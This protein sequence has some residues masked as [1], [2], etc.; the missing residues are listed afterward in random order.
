[1][2]KKSIRPIAIVLQLIVLATVTWSTAWADSPAITRNLSDLQLPADIK[3]HADGRLPI[4]S[5]YQSYMS[6]L[7]RGW[8][9]DV[10]AR[11]QPSGTNFALP[12]IALRSPRVGKA[13]WILAGIHGE[14]PAGPNAIAA[15]IDAI[16]QLGEQRAVVL[17]PLNNPQGYA[18]NWR[19]LNMPVYSAEV[20][21]HSVGDSSW[22][23]V[24]PKKPGFAR[25]ASLPSPEAHAITQYVLALAKTY[26]PECSIDLHE[27][28]LISE[29]YVY[30]QG[31]LG[32]SDPLAGVAVRVLRENRIPLKINGET[33]FGEQVINGVIGPVEDD[34]I[35][36]LI[37]ARQV[38]VDGKVQDGPGAHTVMVFETPAGQI[39]LK[40]RVAAHAALL[41]ALAR[42]MA[43]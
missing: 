40:T 35:D 24:D 7:Q 6:L 37:S 1:M 26:P 15:S 34:S 18:R 43:R 3:T 22:L 42:E 27:D 10:I 4:Q 29:G 14:E 16:A 38:V 23:L 33:R 5:L 8:K 36:E 31:V 21:G 39:D 25:A 30:S 17:L 2:H 32:A 20:E 28:N 12:I 9:L 19:Y 11:S 41:H 13:V